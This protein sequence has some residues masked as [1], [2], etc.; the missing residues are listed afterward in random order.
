MTSEKKTA[1][2]WLLPSGQR[3][4]ARDAGALFLCWLATPDPLCGPP[5]SKTQTGGEDKFSKKKVPAT[6]CPFFFLSVQPHEPATGRR[7]AKMRKFHC[8]R[9]HCAKMSPS[10]F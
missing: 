2:D 3:S 1:E 5:T 7:S 6:T 8:R 10:F 4:A 9:P